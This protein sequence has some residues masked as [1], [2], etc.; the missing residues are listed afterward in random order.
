MHVSSGNRGT[1]RTRHAAAG[2]PAW[3]LL[4]TSC[5][6]ASE[7]DCRSERGYVPHGS[8]GPLGSASCFLLRILNGL[9]AA[10]ADE[11][12]Q[13]REK[14]AWACDSYKEK[15]SP[16]IPDLF[17]RLEQAKPR[18]PRWALAVP[19]KRHR[20]SVPARL[21][22]ACGSRARVRTFDRPRHHSW[23]GL[24]PKPR[25]PLPE[26]LALLADP[27]VPEAPRTARFDRGP[28][29]AR[30]A[31][32]ARPRLAAPTQEIVSGLVSNL[33]SPLADE[34]VNAARFL[35]G[36]RPRGSR[37]GAGLD[38][39]AETS[40][41][42]QR[43]WMGQYHVLGMIAP[44]TE[45]ARASVACADG[46]PPLEIARGASPGCN[47]PRSVRPEAN[48]ALPLLKVLAASPDLA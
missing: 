42:G 43:G 7:I 12:R 36:H 40:V 31:A 41:S 9:A 30:S 2:E 21:L 8:R 27:F 13:V 47:G 17:T 29:P 14:A 10:L 48:S 22:C 11:S 1:L 35:G 45:Y 28:D 46:G 3:H 4:P 6:S 34:G 5:A 18:L 20:S 24:A 15:L 33:T 19:R 39:F 25:R 44:G 23:P 37:R 32:W 38:R 16:L 26:P